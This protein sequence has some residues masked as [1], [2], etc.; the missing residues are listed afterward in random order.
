MGDTTAVRQGLATCI[1][2]VLFGAALVGCGSGGGGD[3]GDDAS[4]TTGDSPDVS[5][6]AAEVQTGGTLIYGVEAETDGYDP[7]NSRFAA[8]GTLVANAIFDPLMTWNQDF[9]PTP[10]LAASVTPADDYMSWEIE[11]RDGISFHDGEPLNAGAVVAFI[12]AQKASALLGSALRPVD[13]AEAVDGD[14]GLLVRV[15]MNMPWAAYPANLTAQGGLVPSPS[16]LTDEDASRNPVGTGP[17]VF[18]SWETDS[19][20]TVVRNEE[21]WRTDAD[22]TQLPYLDTVEFRP[23]TDTQSRVDA[24]RARDVDAIHISDPQGV[25]SLKE[26][27]EEG[28][29]QITYSVGES[30]EGLVLINNEVAPVDDVR[31]RR[32]MAHAIDREG[33]FAVAGVDPADSATGVFRPDSPW[34]VETDYPEFDVEEATRLVEEYEAENGPAEITIKTSAVTVNITNAQY[35]AEA[36]NAVGIDTSVEGV[37]QTVLIG[38]AL[39]G[40]FQVQSWRQFGSQDPDGDYIWWHSSMTEPP[41]ALNMARLRSDA[42]DDAIDRGRSDPDPEARAAAYADLQQAFADEVPYIFL[43]H[44]TWAVAAQNQVRGITGQTLPDGDTS[45]GMIGGVHRLAEVWI[46]Q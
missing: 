33:Y 16:M 1:A 20:L 36:W 4:D 21:Y 44:V 18:D 14:D 23:I 35:V 6:D 40:D 45:P 10:Y 46:E 31:I 29:V 25:T 27:A 24:L 28:D 8:S 17:F 34:Y 26:M 39:S 38:N 11:L 37:E 9:E 5:I 42:V 2:L 22:G 3:G 13:G 43:Y 32:A 41:I 30:D 19:K 15:N 7:V 12:E